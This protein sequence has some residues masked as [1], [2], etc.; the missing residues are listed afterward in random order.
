[1]VLGLGAGVG[2][3]ILIFCDGTGQAG[4]IA[5][6]ENRTNIYKLYRATRCGPDSCID[7]KH[8]VAFYDPG[9]GSP[10]D[11]A[12]IRW[13]IVRWVYSLASQATGLGLTENII[14]AYS[15][16]IRLY[17]EGDRIFLF[18]FSRGA[19]TV[20]CLGGVIAL[21]GVPQTL[22]DGKPLPMDLRGSRKLASSAVRNVYQFCSS[23]PRGQSEYSD[24]MLET[25][26]RIAKRFRA[27]HGSGDLGDEDKAN[28]YPYF[29]GVF[30]TVA[31]LGRIAATMGLAIGVALAVALISFVLSILQLG[32]DLNYIGW[33]LEHFTFENIFSTFGGVLILWA[34]VSL[35]RNY[36]KFDFRVPGYGFWKSVRTFH[37]AHLKQRFTDYGLNP[38][39]MYAKHAISID[40]NRKDFERVR[41]YPTGKRQIDHRDENSNIYFEQ[42]WFAGVHTDVGGGYSENESRLSDITS[43][44][45]LAAASAIPNGIEHDPRVL[46]LFP[47]PA[48]P[49]HDEYK[50]G[51]WQF[52]S[53]NLPRDK[54]SGKVVATMHPTVYER[55]EAGPVVHYDER[56]IYR[57]DNLREHEDFKHYYAGGNPPPQRLAIADSVERR[58]EDQQRA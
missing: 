40:E 54:E 51:R 22:P 14:D 29:I 4:G 25:R 44:W 41:W 27:E 39:I 57:P 28:V 49:Q 32:K 8:Q 42:V 7:P 17:Q 15:A 33:L 53:R 16:I 45:M 21:C 36:V 12:P 37:F 23:R 9:L 2:K 31:A 56:K 1:M 26:Q 38:N 5:F 35:G 20:R 18:G 47:D 30:D 48:G 13:K 11:D 34:I 24:F 10:A 55:F 46:C 52:G 6:D 50:A 43:K 3:N 58:W 19:Y